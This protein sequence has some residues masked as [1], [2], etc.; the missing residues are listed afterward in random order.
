[1]KK[2]LEEAYL[3]K[4]KREIPVGAVI[5]KNGEIIGRGHNQRESNKD[6]FSHAEINAI[7]EATLF[8]KDWRLD[9][10]DIYVTLEPCPMCSGT[11]LQAKFNRVFFGAY[12]E[13]EGC[14]GSVINLLDYPG[15]SWQ[16]E[17]WGGIMQ[18][19]CSD[20]LK[21]FAEEIRKI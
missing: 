3:A 21:Q 16:T 6:I 9:N 19:E 15:M 11:I 18:K 2:A 1:M 20:L 8:L 7:K 17:C 13:R 5:V 4:S 14:G 12:N 10:C